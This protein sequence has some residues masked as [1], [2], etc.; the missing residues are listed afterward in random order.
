MWFIC[1]CHAADNRPPSPNKSFEKIT[2]PPRCTWSEHMLSAKWAP[3]TNSAD[4]KSHNRA[5]QCPFCADFLSS[6]CQFYL[7]AVCLCIFTCKWQHKRTMAVVFHSTNCMCLKLLP[8]IL[9]IA[10]FWLFSYLPGTHC[11]LFLFCFFC[12]GT[13]KIVS[14]HC[15]TSFTYFQANTT[16]RLSSRL[17]DL[18][19]HGWP[20][21]VLHNPVT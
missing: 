20:T 5:T 11:F 17:N 10:I 18:L 13:N 19:H 3:Q 16:F 7:V 8:T 21:I 9:A 14:P 6:T 12:S 2:R 15:L 4:R 1:A